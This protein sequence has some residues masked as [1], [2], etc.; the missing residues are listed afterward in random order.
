VGSKRLLAKMVDV[1]NPLVVLARNLIKSISGVR[2]G[3][4]A[5]VLRTY[6]M[7]TVSTDSRYTRWH[8]P[9]IVLV[10]NHSLSKVSKQRNISRR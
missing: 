8:E 2:R 3:L 6:G 4:E 1:K 5:M 7:V 9:P 10:N